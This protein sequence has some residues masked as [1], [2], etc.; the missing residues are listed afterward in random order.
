MGNR[1]GL[2]EWLQAVEAREGIS[3]FGV[4]KWGAWESITS[5]RS[6]LIWGTLLGNRAP[7]LTWVIDLMSWISSFTTCDL[8]R[9]GELDTSGFHGQKKRHSS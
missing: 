2:Q 4:W 5:L 6:E 8:N 3:A 1:S 7:G 9:T